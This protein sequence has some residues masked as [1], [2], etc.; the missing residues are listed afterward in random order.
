LN[1][2]SWTLVQADGSTS[3]G[4]VNRGN[5]NWGYIV[6]ACNAGGCGPWTATATTV[7][8][9]IPAA[10]AA[11]SAAR[12]SGTTSKPFI[13][14]TWGAVAGATSYNLEETHPQF[15]VMQVYNGPNT[16]YGNYIFATGVVKFRVQACNASGCSGW[17]GYGSI[18]LSS[19]AGAL[20]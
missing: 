3:W 4:A 2:G 9:L 20:R 12:T 16:S 5:G 7:V 18:T 11:P 8:T 15:G 6:Q 14:I 17:S 1:G 13:T 19:G 10:P